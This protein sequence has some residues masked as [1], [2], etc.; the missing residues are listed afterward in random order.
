MDH[1]AKTESYGQKRTNVTETDTERILEF[2]KQIHNVVCHLVDLE[3]HG[4]K[5]D[6]KGEQYWESLFLLCVT[7]HNS[8][9]IVN[10]LQEKLHGQETFIE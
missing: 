1:L 10:I 3:I 4:P 5:K 7:F 8:I 9:L 6:V 2:F